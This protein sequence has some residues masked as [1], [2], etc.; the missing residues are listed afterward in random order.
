MVKKNSRKQRHP[1]RSTN[2]ASQGA[3]A[4]ASGIPRVMRR[5]DDAIHVI[6]NATSANLVWAITNTNAG[7][8]NASSPDL[9]LAVTQSGAIYQQNNGAWA[10]F[11]SPFN[12]Y[13]SCATVFQEYRI[14]DMSVDCYYGVNNGQTIYAGSGA[15]S[16]PM[17]YT[18]E[19][20][21]DAR[22]VQSAATALQYASCQVMQMGNSSGEKNGR[23]TISISRPSAFGAVDNDASL[24]GTIAATSVLRSPWLACGTNSSGGTAAV[25]PH[26]YIKMYFDPVAAGTSAQ[27]Y[28]GNFTFVVRALIEYRGID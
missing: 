8:L 3:L 15:Q 26:G 22:S 13:A 21:E 10:Q 5:A 11:G 9:T 1:R 12:N 20:R 24:I 17:V 7:Q 4:T 6:P 16:L 23:Q 2:A 28:L 25:I 27:V 19:D 14:T 18:L